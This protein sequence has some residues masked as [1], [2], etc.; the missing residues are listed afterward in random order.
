MLV[1]VVSAASK[2]PKVQKAQDDLLTELGITL[3]GKSYMPQAFT[4]QGQGRRK[5]PL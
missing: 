3:P 2:E 5:V 1:V 4:D